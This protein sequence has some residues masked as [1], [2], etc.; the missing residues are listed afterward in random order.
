MKAAVDELREKGKKVGVCMPRVYR[1]WPAKQLAKI[2]DGKKAVAVM[3][4]HLSIGAYGPMYPEVTAAIMQCKKVPKAYNFVFGLGGKDTKVSEYEQVF[5]KI[6]DGT[7]K[8]VNYL[9]V[10]E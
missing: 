2:L 6:A 5:D 10:N 7:A 4:K 8:I 3:D 9:G 1:P